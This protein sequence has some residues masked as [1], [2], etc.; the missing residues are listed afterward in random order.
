MPS[1]TPTPTPSLVPT[2]GLTAW[3]MADAGVVKDGSDYVSL[4]QDQSGQ[5]NDFS[6]ST[7]GSQPQWISTSF[8]IGGGLHFDG[9]DDVLVL[10]GVEL[11]VNDFTIFAVAR[12]YG[13]IGYA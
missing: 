9:V 6:Q 7:S 12:P 4:W 11:G 8:T 2:D 5:G 10:S 1:P 3:L 13:N